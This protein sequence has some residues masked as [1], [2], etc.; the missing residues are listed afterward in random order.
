MP[1]KKIENTA[2]KKQKPKK[3]VVVKEEAQDSA[4][5]RGI[6]TIA[7]LRGMKDV[8]PKE[9]LYWMALVQKAQDVARSFSFHYIVTPILEEAALFTRSLGKGTDIIDKEMYTF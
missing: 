9:S 1:R 3:P 2:P 4:K 7:L 6:R 5:K 8:L